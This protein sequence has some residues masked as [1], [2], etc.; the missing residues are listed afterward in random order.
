MKAKW[1]ASAAIQ[2]VLLQARQQ[3]STPANMNNYTMRVDTGYPWENV[4]IAA[5]DGSGLWQMGPPMVLKTGIT[6]ILY[7]ALITVDNSTAGTDTIWISRM[8]LYSVDDPRTSLGF[9]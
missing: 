4:A 8:H 7:N 6:S 3:P 2:N 9:A 1:N 5:A